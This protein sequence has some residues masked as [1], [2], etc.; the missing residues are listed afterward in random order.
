M[1]FPE[2]EPYR[3]RFPELNQYLPFLD[4]YLAEIRERE[5]DNRVIIPVQLA[6]ALHINEVVALALLRL[7]DKAGILAPRYFAYCDE[8][9]FFLGAFDS[10]D[11]I[12]SVLFCDY[13][14][15]NHTTGEYYVE[16]V[17]VF[18]HDSGKDKHLESQAQT[19]APLYS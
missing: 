1:Q 17:F 4:R 15:R 6:R 10:P 19:G 7:C 11:N 16:L 9:E 12:P 5:P 8:S 3:E 2:L 14:G 13:H 18:R